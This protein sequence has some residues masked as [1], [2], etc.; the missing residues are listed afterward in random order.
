MRIVKIL[1]VVLAVLAAGAGAFLLKVQLTGIPHYP[2]EGVPDLHVEGTP[3][4]IA[5]GMGG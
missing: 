1:G 2:R 4:R 5:R 3:E